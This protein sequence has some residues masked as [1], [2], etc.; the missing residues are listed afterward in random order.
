MSEKAPCLN[1]GMAIWGYGFLG[2]AAGPRMSVRSIS[3]ASQ[4]GRAG[5]LDDARWYLLVRRE[6]PAMQSRLRR[7]VRAQAIAAR[8][9]SRACRTVLEDEFLGIPV[10]KCRPA[11]LAGRE[12]SG[13]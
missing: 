3:A 12:R 13:V 10:M 2:A 5:G 11:S 4:Q 9:F 8:A 1:R 7:P 6:A